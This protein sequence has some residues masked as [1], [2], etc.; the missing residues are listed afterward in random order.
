MAIGGVGQPSGCKSELPQAR[1]FLLLLHGKLMCGQRHPT[2]VGLI[3]L[4]AGVAS[5]PLRP[6]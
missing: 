3:E 6:D 2:M 5:V 4:R 1:G